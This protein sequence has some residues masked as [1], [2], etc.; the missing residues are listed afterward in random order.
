MFSPSNKIYREVGRAKDLTVPAYIQPYTVCFPCVY[1]SGLP[2]WRMCSMWSCNIRLH[3]QYI[4]HDDENKMF[5]TCWR[6]EELNSNIDL[7]SAFC[8]LTNKLIC[9]T[10]DLQVPSENKFTRYC[11]LI[12]RGAEKSL[13]RPTSQ[14]IL[15][16]CENIS[17]DA[18]LVIYIYILLYFSNYCN[19]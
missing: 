15:F 17:F 16:N 4:L 19:K 7:K 14:C 3:V 18:S 11:V 13:A 9:K 12:Y 1:A 6:Q 8:W 5:E 10:A 2:G